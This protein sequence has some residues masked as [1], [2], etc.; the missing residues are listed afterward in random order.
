M[1]YGNNILLF[2]GEYLNGEKLLK[3]KK[4]KLKYIG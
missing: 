4:G 2:E 3:R 1:I